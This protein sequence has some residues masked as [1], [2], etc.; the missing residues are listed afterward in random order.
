MTEIK[1][2]NIEKLI[3]GRL[4]FTIPQ[5]LATGR[6][7][8]GIVGRNGAGKST[9]AHL[10]TGA[11]QDY[12]GQRLVDAPVTY[13]TQI[14]P[15]EDRSGGQAMMAR[16]REALS[17]RPE[18]LILDEPSSNLD[19]PHQAWLIKKL[20]QYHGL[21]LL[22]S[23]DRQ[24]LNAVTTQT[25]AVSHQVFTAYAG[26]YAAYMAQKAQTIATQQ[27]AYTRQNRHEHDLKLAM[28]ARKEKAQRIRKGN[29]RMTASERSNSKSLREAT[30][31]KMDRTAKNLMTRAARE[32]TVTKPFTQVGFKLVA[33]DFPAFTG[34]T[35]VSASDLTLHEYDETL[36]KQTSFQIK[37]GDRVALTGPNGCGKT[38]LL[39]AILTGH[40]GLSVSPSAKIGVFKQDMTALEGHLTVWQTVR[41]ASQLPDQTIRNIMGA[42]GLPARFYEQAVAGLSGGELVKLQLVCI[43]VGAYN[44]LMLDE[45]TN[46]LDVDALDALA[47]YL[48]NYPGTI[49]FVSHDVVFR[50]QVTT[51]TLAFKQQH[52][53]DPDQVAVKASAPSDLPLLQFKYDQLMADPEAS[54]ADIQKLRDQI[55]A[56]K[57]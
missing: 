21:L 13:V 22:I 2:S 32:A 47:D 36:L 26:N 23:H 14:A 41:A 54:T 9:L 46:Y 56:A 43:L 16:V 7:H 18:I 40:P 55:E 51:R 39:T 24:L 11:D 15:T 6:D 3:N 30:A 17:G 33:T 45:P 31:A 50:Q 1:L 20:R 57:K 37:P 27:A 10:L 34:K 4:L 48:Q 19:E 5:L 28:Q 12:T 44:V 49:I 42:L 25:W 38:T 52:L 8:I 35:V 53:V 29:R